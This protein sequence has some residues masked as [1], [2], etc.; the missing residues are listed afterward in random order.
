MVGQTIFILKHLE[1]TKEDSFFISSR[2]VQ[3]T[4]GGVEEEERDIERGTWNP[5]TFIK[6]SS[7]IFD[8]FERKR[9]ELNS[10]LFAGVSQQYLSSLGGHGLTMRQT[11]K[12]LRVTSN[13]VGLYN[14]IRYNYIPL[15]SSYKFTMKLSLNDITSEIFRYEKLIKDG[16]YSDNC[17]DYLSYSILYI[18]ENIKKYSL[19]VYKLLANEE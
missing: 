14:L 3:H 4:P 13:N 5:L 2:I 10:T 12:A 16:H 7:I 18:I 8:I 1:S 17:N 6:R 11:L 9:K 19:A 15:V